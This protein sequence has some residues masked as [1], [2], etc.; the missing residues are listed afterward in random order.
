MT[1]ERFAELQ[2]RLQKHGL[3]VTRESSDRTIE[4]FRVTSIDG[5]TRLFGPQDLERLDKRRALRAGLRLGQS[6]IGGAP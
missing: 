2:R 5:K 4:W 3:N 1:N 6:L